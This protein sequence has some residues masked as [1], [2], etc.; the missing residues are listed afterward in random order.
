MKLE[1]RTAVVRFET[2]FQF[3]L[4]YLADNKMTW[5]S[6]AEDG[7]G[8]ETD[9]IYTKE[10]TDDL[11]SVSWIESTGNSIT[12]HINLAEGT[13]WAFMSWNDPEA[14]G[15]RQTLTHSGTFEFIN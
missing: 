5:T 12:H 14:F 6:L 3:Q 15:Q 1:G 4:E 11:I 7:L 10:L 9:R 8:S 13:V 2:G